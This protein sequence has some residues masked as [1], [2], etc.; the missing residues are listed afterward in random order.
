MRNCDEKAPGE[1]RTCGH[2][3]P[4]NG[5]FAGLVFGLALHADDLHPAS[6]EWSG[7]AHLGGTTM[8]FV[9]PNIQLRL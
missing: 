3:L 7:Y 5:V 8:E 9:R 2:L 1:E 4:H 6:V